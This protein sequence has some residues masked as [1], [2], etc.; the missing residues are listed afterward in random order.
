MATDPTDD[1]LVR[2]ERLSRDK[3]I[4]VEM[5][6]YEEDPGVFVATANWSDRRGNLDWNDYA[7][8]TLREALTKL[9]EAEEKRDD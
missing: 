1:L 7:A 9:V 5:N 6:V 3:S 8:P 4:R 2:L